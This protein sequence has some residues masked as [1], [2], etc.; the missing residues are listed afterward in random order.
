MAGLRFCNTCISLGLSL[1][2]VEL[3][4]SKFLDK[5]N[6]SNYQSPRGWHRKCL[7]KKLKVSEVPH[8]KHQVA[9]PP[10]QA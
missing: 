9:L 5:K 4:D 6:D 10:L 3:R 8:P 7:C 1:T 2:R